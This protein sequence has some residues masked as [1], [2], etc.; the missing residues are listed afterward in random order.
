MAETLKALSDAL[1]GYVES[2]SAGIV[3]VDGRKRLGATGMV[4]GED[5]VIVTA[6]HVVRRDDGIKVTLPDGSSHSATLI[7][8]AEQA[9]IAV[10]RVDATLTPLTKPAEDDVLKVGHLVL[11]LGK[12]GDQTQATLGVVSALGSRRMEGTIQTDVVMYP[13]F[14]G[15]PLID[16]SGQVRGMNTSGFSRGASITIGNG[17]I[18]SVVETLL[19]HGRMRQGYLGVGAQP[20]RLP[21]D[22]AEELGQET[23]LMLASVEA[24]SPAQTSGLFMGDVIVSVD[25]DP[26]PTLDALL[27]LLTGERVGKEVPVQVVRSGA[28][29]TVNVTIGERV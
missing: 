10:L 11:A 17:H 6:H 27:G 22:L 14:S 13:G 21:D 28:I 8:R 23:G 4:W 20:V 26:T 15:G 2:A 16:A 9:D 12:P 5:G 19:A 18:N 7:G 25:G 24:N 1:A 3:R 29:Q